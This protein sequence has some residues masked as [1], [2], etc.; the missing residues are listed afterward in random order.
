MIMIT[1]MIMVIMMTMMTMMIILHHLS[2]I[3]LNIPDQEKE[4]VDE[5]LYIL[6]TNGEYKNTV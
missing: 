4:E 3:A 5:G 1:M 6:M 2:V